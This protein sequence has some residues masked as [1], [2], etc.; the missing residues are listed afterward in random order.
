M[1]R[2]DN[3]LTMLSNLFSATCQKT[4]CCVV[5]MLLESRN[6]G[7]ERSSLENKL[8][9]YPLMRAM[10]LGISHAV[11][12]ASNVSVMRSLSATQHLQRWCGRCLQTAWDRHIVD[13]SLFLPPKAGTL[14]SHPHRNAGVLRAGYGTGPVV[15][16]T[17]V[18]KKTTA[19]QQYACTLQMH[20]RKTKR[21]RSP[22]ASD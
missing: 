9:D 20:R 5:I 11:D 2:P 17:A 15:Y 12:S 8:C 4:G 16:T 7:S 1:S 10:L 6:T 14:C 3:L 13:T 18:K 19:V 21:V 22:V